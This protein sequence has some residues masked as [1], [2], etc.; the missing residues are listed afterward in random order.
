MLAATVTVVTSDLSITSH[1]GNTCRA[2][3]MAFHLLS[4]SISFASVL[5]L[6]IF[7][8]SDASAL[9][10]WLPLWIYTLYVPGRMVNTVT[11]G[12]S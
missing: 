8:K 5:G 10:Q 6:P 4:F 3:T 7:F 2:A 12:R 1:G 9:R 11:Q